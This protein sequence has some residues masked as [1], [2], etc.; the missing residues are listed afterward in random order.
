MLC[1]SLTLPW[2]LMTVPVPGSKRTGMT[3]FHV[4]GT[5]IAAV[6]RVVGTFCLSIFS[7]GIRRSRQCAWTD[8]DALLTNQILLPWDGRLHDM[9]P[10][11]TTL[12]KISSQLVGLFP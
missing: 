1:R 10:V 7:T 3:S 6:V 9:L 4:N 2:L 8:E 5:P 12:S 11:W